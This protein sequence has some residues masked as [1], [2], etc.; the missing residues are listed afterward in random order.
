MYILELPDTNLTIAH[1]AP[2]VDC[3]GRPLTRSGH[4]CRFSR[5][6][7]IRVKQPHRCAGIAHPGNGR[8]IILVMFYC[9][10]IRQLQRNRYSRRLR[11]DP[12]GRDITDFL[13]NVQNDS[14]KRPVIHLCLKSPPYDLC[15]R[16]SFGFRRTDNLELDRSVINTLARQRYNGT[17]YYYIDFPQPRRADSEITSHT[18]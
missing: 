1:R 7:V 9:R 11:L 18:G 17:L 14:L 5:D 4:K 6:R 12:P 8:L 3:S 13:H 16:W 15:R 2:F 10:R